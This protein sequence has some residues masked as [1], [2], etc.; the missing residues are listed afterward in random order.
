M[1]SHPFLVHQE[2][3]G[4]PFAQFDLS[5]QLHCYCRMPAIYDRMQQC[6]T[7]KQPYHFSLH[8]VTR[9]S[10]WTQTAFRCLVHLSF[11]LSPT[12][13]DQGQT[14]K[15]Q[16]YCCKETFSKGWLLGKPSSFS[17]LFFFLFSPEVVN[18][19]AVPGA[20]VCQRMLNSLWQNL[21]FIPQNGK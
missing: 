3:K 4:L 6:V 18:I 14:Y 12:A 11:L 7:C 1:P 19:H 15:V 13:C 17:F 5:I 21:L 10:N 16:V 8:W 9:E 20:C 2:G